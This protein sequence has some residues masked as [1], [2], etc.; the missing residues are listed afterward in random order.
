[1]FA[2]PERL[3]F[4]FDYIS[5]NAWLAWNRVPALA[6]RHG[7]KLE[8]VPVLFAG[9][10]DALGH[11]GP[12]EVAPKRD[13]MLWNVL[14]KAQQ[15]GIALAPPH[16]HPFNPLWPL[17]LS[18]CELPEAQ[19]LRLIDGLFRATWVDGRPVHEP[20][21][22]RSVLA[23]SGLDA[24][25]WLTDAASEPAKRRLRQNTEGALASGVFGVPTMM[26]RG[27]LFWG[28][29][30]LEFL[31][32]FLQGRDPLGDRAALRA[33]S[34]VRPTAQRRFLS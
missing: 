8:P 32:L 34:E 4:F 22:L 2:D 9:L 14:R 28:F 12:A 6:Q 16:S 33:W 11:K 31:E 19:R 20:E 10:L 15:L 29:D 1:M 17:R 18:C 24:D 7:L 3:Y 13:W 23:E 30:D 5:H 25:T 26:V 21:A 27:E